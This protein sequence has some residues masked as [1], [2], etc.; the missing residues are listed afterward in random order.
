MIRGLVWI[1]CR[2]LVVLAMQIVVLGLSR[3]YNSC[4]GRLGVNFYPAMSYIPLD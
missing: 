4:V 1:L 2:V 3:F